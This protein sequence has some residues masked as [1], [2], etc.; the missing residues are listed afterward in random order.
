MLKPVADH[1]YA[2]KPLDLQILWIR[3]IHVDAYM[4]GDIWLVGGAERDLVVDSGMGIVPPAYCESLR[5]LSE[6]PVRRAYPGHYG[7]FDGPAWR[8]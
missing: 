8:S 6:L 7:P 4:A 2:I 5:R 3:E 1:W